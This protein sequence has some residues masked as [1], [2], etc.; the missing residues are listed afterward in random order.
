MD[1]LERLTRRSSAMAD[2]SEGAGGGGKSLLPG[3][4]QKKTVGGGENK[5]RALPTKTKGQQQHQNWNTKLRKKVMGPMAIRIK[6]KVIRRKAKSMK[7][8]LM[9]AGGT[10]GKNLA[11]WHART[12]IPA[13]PHCPVTARHADTSPNP[14]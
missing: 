12:C 3:T 6:Q 8:L 9:M 4:G 11:G 7:T 14:L 10:G 2:H 1:A 13:R 5:K